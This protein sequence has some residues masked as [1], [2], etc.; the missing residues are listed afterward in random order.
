MSFAVRSAVFL[1]SLVVWSAPPGVAQTV[2]RPDPL[3]LRPGDAVRL[4]VRDEPGLKG[5]YT[6]DPEGQILLP[7]VGL[8]RVAGRDFDE[9]RREVVDRYGHELVRGE[10]QIVPLLRIAVLGEVRQPALYPVDPTYTLADVLALA[11][12]LAGSA[13]PK[14]VALVRGGQTIPLVVRDGAPTLDAGF[15]SGDQLVVGRRSWLRENATALVT[16]G[17]S[18]AV[19]VVTA[20]VVR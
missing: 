16:T 4:L 17:A 6:V 3:R 18:I 11:G 13:D 10:V 2:A 7:M 9:V 15:R 20:L 8:T 19:A 5:E 14:H 1:L 12:G